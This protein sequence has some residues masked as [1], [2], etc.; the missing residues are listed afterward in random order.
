MTNALAQ[1]ELTAAQGHIMGYLA[2]RDTP[3][4]S[5]DIEEVFHLSH[6]TV[7]GLLSRLEKKGFIEFRPDEADRRCKRI[8]MLPKG[9]E[10]IELMHQTICSTEQQLVQG[11]TE[12]ECAQFSA[13]LERAIAN[14]GGNP[15]CKPHKEETKRH[16]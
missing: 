9:H 6:P 7:S 1:M 2:H 3:P 11:F 4:C 13:L 12:E 5:R 16:D 10:C 8:C 15:C 14:M